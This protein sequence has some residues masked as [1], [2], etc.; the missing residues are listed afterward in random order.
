MLTPAQVAALRDKAG[1]VTDSLVDFLVTDIAERISEAG[2]FTNTAAYEAWRAQKLGLS[3]KELKKE[4]QKRLKLSTA[5][6]NQMFAQVAQ[7]SYSNDIKRLGAKA[8]AFEENTSLQQ[9][10]DSS[11]KL[12]QDDFTNI[13]QTMGFV[14]PD[15]RFHELT[16]AY[17]RSCD[18]AFEKVANGAQDYNSAVRD[19]TREL[20]K[21][22]IRVMDYESGVHTSMEAAVRRNI[23][24]GLGLM[25]EQITQQNHDD[26]GCDGWEISAHGGC[27]PDHE[28]IQGK[29]YSD[30]E[31]T[32]LNNSLVRRIGTLNCGHSAMPIIL[33]V[34]EPQYTKEE[35]E[36]FRQQNEEGITYNGKHYTLYEAT[37]RQSNLE[38][39]IRNWKRRILI[40][41]KLGDKDALQTDQIR[42]QLLK[43][44]YSRFSKAANLPMR[45]ERMEAAGFDWK[46]GKAAEQVAKAAEARA[47]KNYADFDI[48]EGGKYKVLPFDN[49]TDYHDYIH[50]EYNAQRVSDA[51]NAVL[52]AVDGGYIQ[53]SVGYKDING[54]MRGLKASLDNP[55]CQKTMDVLIRRTASPTL[56]HDYIGYRKVSPSY[57]HDVLGLNTEGKLKSVGNPWE[58]FKDVQSAQELSRE[59]N[60]LVGTEKARITDKAVTSVSLCEKLNFF[61]HRPVEFEIQM[62]T[63]TKGLIT[64]NYPESEF[65]AKPNSTLEI[66]GSMVYDDSGKPCIRIFARMIQD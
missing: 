42:L 2:Q 50:P 24:G 48:T 14:G 61:K 27:A 43:Q 6:I 40:D 10:L 26:L 58:K 44:E 31:Y 54:Y 49:T 3:Q 63:G 47:I 9:I 28:P 8:V 11:V 17:Q 18:F 62:P 36:E 53:N 22:G 25:N 65:I 37:Q 4:L 64:T 46:K 39:A 19:A 52:Y 55:K 57:L 45:H 38:T 29:Q 5:E 34:N 41:E 13:T 30:A 15:G 56:K 51:D 33:G 16:E 35:L 12:A 7:T 20:A 23:M 21:R 66:L 1:Q 32:R 60:N 59:I